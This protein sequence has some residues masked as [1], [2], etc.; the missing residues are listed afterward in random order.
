MACMM[1]FLQP[2]G[3]P[4]EVNIHFPESL[5]N[6]DEI[7]VFVFP[8]LQMCLVSRSFLS[9]KDDL[10]F[11]RTCENSPSRL[12]WV[13]LLVRFRLRLRLSALDLRSG[14]VGCRVLLRRLHWRR[15]LL[16]LRFGLR[17]LCRRCLPLGHRLVLG[18]RSL[19]LW[20]WLLVLRRRLMS[21]CRLLMHRLLHRS[22]ML[23]LGFGL[24]A[25]G[26][27]HRRGLL[28]NRLLHRRWGLLLR[29]GIWVH[30]LLDRLRML[31]LYRLR[32]LLRLLRIHGNV[33]L[34]R[35]WT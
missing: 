26:L 8:R 32:M 11:R 13:F 14:L 16:L 34:W 20:R 31:L 5:P 28:A 22:W 3:V 7:G 1:R 4:A 15:L 2:N 30:C 10:R 29:R 18:R 24:L 17:M 27:S 35:C 6:A 19:T 9:R 21:R 12:L 25:N 33:L 23:L